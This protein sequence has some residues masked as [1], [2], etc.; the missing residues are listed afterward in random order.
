[1]DQA[2]AKFATKSPLTAKGLLQ[3]LVLLLRTLSDPT[4]VQREF[5]L[6]FRSGH[7]H[8]GVDVARETKYA[9]A[10]L[11]SIDA[12]F[13]TRELDVFEENR[14]RH[15]DFLK[16]VHFTVTGSQSNLDDLFGRL[17]EFTRTVQLMTPTEL[18]QLADR[19]VLESMVR[20]VV[21]D[22][23]RTRRLEDAAAKLAKE[24]IDQDAKAMYDD[25]SKLANFRLAIQ[26]ANP[27]DVS[28]K[29]IFAIEDFSFDSP[30]YLDNNTTLA[31]LFDYPTKYQ[32]RLVLVEWVSPT[33]GN[34][35]AAILE[36]MDE[37]KVTWFIL[38]AEKPERL[39][40]PATI[41]LILDHTSPRS[42]GFVYQ[43]PHHIR[44]NLPTRPVAGRDG[45]PGGARVVL[46]PKAIAAQR[47]PT[48]L[49]QLIR[50]KEKGGLDLGIRFKLAKKLVDAVHLMHTAGFTH[51]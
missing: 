20:D 33:R 5:G 45:Q 43:L 44:G 9:C 15:M 16:Q 49:R 39:L 35:P 26:A 30:Y 17:D 50:E 28:R 37:T 19:R 21:K 31:R 38:H 32:S 8:A 1:M 36:T 40:L 4:K 13:S 25:L 3:Q 24:S 12:R 2:I 18:R 7:L 11:D 42:I 48:N 51:R 22:A 41:G 14:R 46:S 47:L 34:S 10:F 29:K 23:D 27:A 6:T